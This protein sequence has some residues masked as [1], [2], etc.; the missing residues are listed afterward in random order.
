M[1][2]KGILGVHGQVVAAPF[3]PLFSKWVPGGLWRQSA[4]LALKVRNQITA[5]VSLLGEDLLL[6]QIED[7]PL[8]PVVG[9]LMLR[10]D[11]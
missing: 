11:R 4:L 9:L 10:S 7:C 2:Y 3:S 5:H 1:E 6:Q 8:K